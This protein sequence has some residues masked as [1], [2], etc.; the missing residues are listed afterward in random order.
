MA[1]IL[2]HGDSDGVCSGAVYQAFL[3]SKG[4]ETNIYFTHPAGLLKDLLEFTK[5]GDDIYIADIAL[6]ESSYRDVMRLLEERGKSGRVVY[7]D[8][9]PLPEGFETPKNIEFFHDTCCSA[10]ELTFRYFEKDLDADFTRVALYGAIGDYIDETP[11]VREHIARWDKRF[12]YYEAGVLI[13]GI[14]G[15]GRNYD[16]KRLVVEH[17]SQNKLPSSLKELSEKALK[18]S[19]LDEELR[20]W[21]KKNVRN[22]GIVSIAENPPGSVGRAA[23]YARIYGGGLIGVAYEN[24]GGILVSSLRSPYVDLNRLLRTISRELNIQGGGHSFAAGAR[25]PIGLLDVF[26]EKI[27]SYYQKFKLS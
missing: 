21:V 25:I 16:F 10:S 27:N 9:H 14:E 4:I 5:Q 24:R 12:I 15:T 8:H 2:V 13:Q 7:I 11:W 18:Q 26:I 6:D 19:A 17:L 20:L 3:K 1:K 22:K 23:N